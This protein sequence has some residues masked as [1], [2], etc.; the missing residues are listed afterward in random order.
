MQDTAGTEQ[1]QAMNRL[2]YRG[3]IV[4]IICYGNYFIF[5]LQGR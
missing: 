2:Y 5:Y 1:Y 4:A 3:A